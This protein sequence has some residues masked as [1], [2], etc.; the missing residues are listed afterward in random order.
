MNSQ[1]TIAVLFGGVIGTLLGLLAT[2]LFVVTADE[3][4]DQRRV[5]DEVAR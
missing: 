4:D 1:L 3:D 5:A 2:V